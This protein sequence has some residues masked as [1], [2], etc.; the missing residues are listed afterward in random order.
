MFDGCYKLSAVTCLATDISA[1]SCTTEWL[2]VAGRDVTGT[3]TFTKNPSMNDW[4]SDASG[5]PSGWTVQDA[6]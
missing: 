4:P 2:G 1:N 5:I 3:K 6:Q